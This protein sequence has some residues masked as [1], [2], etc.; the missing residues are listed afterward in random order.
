MSKDSTTP[1]K[2]IRADEN[3]ERQRNGTASM[4]L[5][6]LNEAY[7]DENHPQHDEAVKEFEKLA[8]ALGPRM[9]EYQKAFSDTVA[10][11][12]FTKQPWLDTY[13][14]FGQQFES[15]QKA[16]T[17][18]FNAAMKASTSALLN[19][20]INIPS[21]IDKSPTPPIYPLANHLKTIDE[22]LTQGIQERAEREQQQQEL[23]QK[24]YEAIEALVAQ[25]AQHTREMAALREQQAQSDE[26][27]SRA[28][29]WNLIL[30]MLTLLVAIASFGVSL[31][32]FTKGDT[33]PAP[34]PAPVRSSH[35][36]IS[37]SP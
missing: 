11:A 7:K 20:T 16:A 36:L 6:E 9:A 2:H 14:V 27:S 37:S 21:I 31:F 15:A 33:P 35:P 22:S 3:K 26:R 24:Q 12:S 23:A 19:S 13:K 34:S 30:V 28:T 10:S 25:Q 18:S 32:S 17:Q 4:R 8:T 5:R 1:K 29:R